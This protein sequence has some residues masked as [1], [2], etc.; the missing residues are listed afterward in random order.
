MERGA[1]GLGTVEAERIG[2]ATMTSAAGRLRKPPSVVAPT[3]AEDPPPSPGV[4]GGRS[5]SGT[6]MAGKRDAAWIPTE[7]GIGLAGLVDE[8]PE[9]DRRRGVSAAQIPM[10]GKAATSDDSLLFRSLPVLHA[11]MSLS[12]LPLLLSLMALAAPAE[13]TTARP[14]SPRPMLISVGAEDA[15]HRAGL[16]RFDATG[17]ISC[18]QRKGQPS[19]QC[20]FG[21]ARAGGGTATVVVTGPDGRRRSLFFVKGV[22]SSADTTQADGAPGTHGHKHADVYHVNVGEEHYDIPEAVIYGG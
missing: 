11:P 2:S 18:S 17:T 22:F 1:I 7:R 4:A 12:A 13:A 9:S 6:A 21:V 20:R 5:G 8:D 10:P 3:R 14:E 16:G 15:A 19:S